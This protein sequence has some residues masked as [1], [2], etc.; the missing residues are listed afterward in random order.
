MAWR[1]RLFQQ[2]RHRTLILEQVQGKPLLV[3]PEV[4]NPTLFRSSV[5]FVEQ[6]KAHIPE[7][8]LVLDMGTGSGIGAVFAAETARQVVAVDI[9]PEAVRCA[10]LN[11]LL[12]RVE[13]CVDVREGD[14]FAPVEGQRFDVVLFNPPFYRG[15]PHDAYDHAWRGLDVVARFAAGL[16][17]HLTP[18]G[19]ALVVLSTNS[20]LA[21]FLEAFALNALNVEAIAQRHLV[22]EIVTVYRLTPEDHTHFTPFPSPS[23]TV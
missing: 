1:F 10:R 15:T 5:F 6:F 9:N 23:P 22:S 8:A 20:D 13:Q 21:H 7:N 3:L 2:H 4:F 19:C 17:T 18:N 12:N 14:L 11:A 16:R